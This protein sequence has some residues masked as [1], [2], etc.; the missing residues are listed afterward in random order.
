MQQ[1]SAFHFESFEAFIKDP[2]IVNSFIFTILLAICV[3]LIGAVILRIYNNMTGSES[4]CLLPMCN[5]ISVGKILEIF[6]DNSE[7]PEMIDEDDLLGN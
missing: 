7:V 6:V 5:E 2:Q 3:P 1:Q 4:E